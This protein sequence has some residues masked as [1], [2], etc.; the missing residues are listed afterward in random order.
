MYEIVRLYIEAELVYPPLNLQIY[1]E[2]TLKYLQSS[3]VNL[4]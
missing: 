1:I 4:I 2:R 3:T